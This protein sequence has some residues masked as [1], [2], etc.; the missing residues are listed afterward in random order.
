MKNHDWA[1]WQ[2]S[3]V[4]RVTINGKLSQVDANIFKGPLATLKHNLGIVD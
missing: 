4:A 2:F 1:L 3:E